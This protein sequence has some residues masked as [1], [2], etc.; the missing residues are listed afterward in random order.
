LE[1]IYCW[2]GS[3]PDPTRHVKLDLN[4]QFSLTAKTAMPKGL[5]GRSTPYGGQV[6]VGRFRCASL[7]SGIKCTEVR[8][9]RGFV[10]NIAG[11]TRVGP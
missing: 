4:G 8:T 5:G 11:V 1:T 9:G 2:I 7:R 6:T 3:S 10:F